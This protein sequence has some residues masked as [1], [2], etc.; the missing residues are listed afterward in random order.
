MITFYTVDF[1]I[2]CYN[3]SNTL[4]WYIREFLEFTS[5][6]QCLMI[7]GRGRLLVISCLIYR[8]L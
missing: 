4:L 8:H 6:S 1:L 5:R 2:L 3:R 7:H